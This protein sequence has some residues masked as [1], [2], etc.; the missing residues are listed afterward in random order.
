M[1][2]SIALI[3]AILIMVSLCACGKDINTNGD[4]NLDGNVG[5]ITT[6]DNATEVQNIVPTPSEEYL[7][8]KE[9]NTKTDAVTIYEYDD[10]HHCVSEVV[11]RKDGT[12]H[13]K[14][15]S[16]T[17][18]DDGSYTVTISNNEASDIDYEEYDAEGRLVKRIDNYGGKYEKTA[19]YKYDASGNLIERNYDGQT[20]A[21]EY[22][23]NN[24]MVRET[25]YKNDGSVDTVTEYKYNENGK[26]IG[27]VFY[28]GDEVHEG[29]EFDWE[30]EYDE[31]GRMITETR[32]TVRSNGKERVFY[33]YDENGGMCKKTEGYMEYEYR[34]ASEC[35]I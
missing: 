28:E 26:Q 8:Y 1:K 4:E 27:S 3:L 19:D 21:M 33:E 10:K 13:E 11:H 29:L 9:T 17:Y 18:A 30:F 25:V 6:E 2:K 15:Y 14:V 34:P 12:T 31:F 23:S 32:I 24:L 5:A 22:D 35:I 7:L 20:T 16:N